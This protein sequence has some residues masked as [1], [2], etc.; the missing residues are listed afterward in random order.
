MNL[1]YKKA[2]LKD[3]DILTKKRIE[4][5]REA[6]QLSEDTSKIMAVCALHFQHG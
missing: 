5:L 6:N 2:M 3:I 1:K 4:V